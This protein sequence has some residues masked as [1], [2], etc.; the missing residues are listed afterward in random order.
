MR[1]PPLEMASSRRAVAFRC[2]A[3][4]DLVLAFDVMTTSDK[5]NVD[6]AAVEADYRAG[7][8]SENSI[9]DSYDISRALLRK[10]AKKNGWS[11][12]DAPKVKIAVRK[13]LAV[14]ALKEAG[15]RRHTQAAAVEI[16]A[17]NQA[18]VV[19]RHRRQAHTYQR[20]VERMFEELTLSSESAGRLVEL[21]KAADVNGDIDAKELR[22]AINNLVRLPVRSVILK[23]LVAGFSRLVDI[24][25]RSHGIKE[26]EGEGS[27]EEQLDKLRQASAR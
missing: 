5:K 7:A 16:T 22:A 19:I 26:D 6:W 12:D 9:A 23:D 10:R 27:Y 25:R 21:A 14:A 4:C 15:I 2:R 17:E 24:E 3:S 20:L 13:K 1:R 11:R 18:G 8:L